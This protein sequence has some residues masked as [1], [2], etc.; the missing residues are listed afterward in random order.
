MNT[1]AKHNQDSDEE[2]FELLKPLGV[3]G[4][5]QTFLARVVDEDLREEYG[6]EQVALKIP[7]SAKK[8]RAIRNDIG[9]NLTVHLR[10]KGLR[11]M[12]IV[13]YLGFEIFRNQIVMAME[14]MPQGSLRRVVGDIGRQKQVPV[15]DAVRIAQEVLKGLAI[16]HQE[17]VFHRDIKPENIL[18]DGRVAKV[19]DLGIAR[20]LDSNELASTTT[21]TI[22]Y[23]SPE[24]LGEEGASF[25]SDIWSLGVTL[26]EMLAGKLPFGTKDTSI[27]TIAD[28][29]RK[30]EHVPVC[31]VCRN[32][33]VQLSRIVDRAMSKQASKRYVKAEEMYDDLASLGRAP[34][35]AFEEE[36]A[37][38]EGLMNATEHDDAVERKLQ[39]IVGK[40]PDNPKAYQYLG[41]FYNRRMQY[42]EAA[43]VF[44][45]G[46]K[47]DP[48]CALLHWD[49]A[50][51]YQNMGKPREA[52]QCFEK[53]LSLDLDP[54]FK[55]T[56]ATLLRALK[57]GNGR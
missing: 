53:A 38:I 25:P 31:E 50:L 49:L 43:R 45:K 24:I 34:K 18:M 16:I 23:M 5:A 54:I 3:G 22:Y 12:N 41:E 26:Y 40:C 51:A 9:M 44:R 21:G 4:F 27:G 2:P 30:S 15:E 10:I 35:S 6:V 33:P 37:G 19:A 46:L 7:L 8:A 17:H 13:R 28:L 1:A 56:A 36:I 42:E 52:V 55:R 32:I 57:V 20:I 48:N 29:I 47:C 11:S 39:Q 14:Y